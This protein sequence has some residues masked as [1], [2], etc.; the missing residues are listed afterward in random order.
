ML[1]YSGIISAKQVLEDNGVLKIEVE[2]GSESQILFEDANKT[3]LQ[4]F[5]DS[6]GLELDLVLIKDDEQKLIEKMRSL[7]GERLIIEE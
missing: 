1:A 3:V 2:Y 7:I 4:K 5:C 6:S